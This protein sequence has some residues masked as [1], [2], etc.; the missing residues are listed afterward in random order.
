M[1]LD[2]ER[3]MSHA[4]GRPVCDRHVTLKGLTYSL[5]QHL[6]KTT[7]NSAMQPLTSQCIRASAQ[8]RQPFLVS[9][10]GELEY[11][12]ST[13]WFKG[14]PAQGT[15]GEE[16]RM[17]RS[18]ALCSASHRSL[19]GTQARIPARWDSGERDRGRGVR[20]S[21]A[22]SNGGAHVV[23]AALREQQGPYLNSHFPFFSSKTIQR[24]LKKKKKRKTIR[25]YYL[26]CSKS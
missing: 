18:C 12:L 4:K 16:H 17:Q 11:I 5:R 9:P 2:P 6:K 21:E 13:K 20:A 15:S 1:N 14:E 19:P 8:R 23:C 10:G 24:L 7:W 26:F 3:Q 22:G 25:G